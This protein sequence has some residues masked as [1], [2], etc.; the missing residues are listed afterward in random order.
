MILGILDWNGMLAILTAKPVLVG[1]HLVLAIVGIDAFLWLL[2]EIVANAG[3]VRRRTAVVII[4]IFGFLGSWIAGGYYYVT[5][6]GPLV[7]PVI[8]A[9]SA[10]WAHTIAMEA[11][12]HMFLFIIPLAVTALLL[13]RLD[14]ATLN[15]YGLKRVAAW[16]AG[17]VAGLG[18]AIGLLGFVI[19]AAARW[20]IIK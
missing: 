19:S 10:P 8:K 12:E 18:L 5:F 20:G 6:Y 16:L 7:K 9:G 3:S 4:G 13:T 15:G 11:K 14:A 1:I 2:G 17:T